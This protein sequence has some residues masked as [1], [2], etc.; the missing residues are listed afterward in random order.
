MDFEGKLKAIFNFIIDNRSLGGEWFKMMK[1]TGAYIAAKRIEQD[2]SEEEL[3]K[4]LNVTVTQ[5]E[6]WERGDKLPGILQ[7]EPL[8]SVLGCNVTQLLQGDDAASADVLVMRLLRK[9][10]KYKGLFVAIIG[11][12]LTQLPFTVLF[13]AES[14]AGQFI[15]GLVTGVSTG[16]ALV[17]VCVFSYGLALFLKN[18]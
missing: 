6:K 8:C 17:G 12:L 7:L 5:V 3:A 9:V 13:V 1:K 15:S 16:C 14:A 2:I 10:E 11:L 4:N 18:K